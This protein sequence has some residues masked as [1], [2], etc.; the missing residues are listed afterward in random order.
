M[1]ENSPAHVSIGQVLLR[2]PLPEPLNCDFSLGSGTDN[3]TITSIGPS[4]AT[5]SGLINIG[6]DGQLQLGRA[7]DRETDGEWLEAV[8]TV[9]ACPPITVVDTVEDTAE[10]KAWIRLHVLD[11]NDHL[12][13]FD[14][15]N[16]RELLISDATP[17]GS[18]LTR[19]RIP[20][21]L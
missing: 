11:T 13:E 17:I 9:G 6:F 7:L 14:E 16:V 5:V 8:V 18:E 3:H 19:S 10:Q 15:T 20:D 1:S 12:P 4:N 21:F 2:P